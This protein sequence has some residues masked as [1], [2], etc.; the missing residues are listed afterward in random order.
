[1]ILKRKLHTV[2]LNITPNRYFNKH[3]DSI[4]AAFPEI[5]QHARVNMGHLSAA[6]HNRCV[7]PRVFYEINAGETL[8]LLSETTA[9]PF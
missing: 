1:M 9:C 2:T 3:R 5:T 4:L 8:L 7:I 6:A